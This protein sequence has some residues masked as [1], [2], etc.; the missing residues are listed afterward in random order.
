MTSLVSGYFYLSI[1]SLQRFYR[2]CCGFDFYTLLFVKYKLQSIL[3]SVLWILCMINDVDL[4]Y[5]ELLFVKYCLQCICILL[6]ML[7]CGFYVVDLIYSI[8]LFVKYCLQSE[9]VE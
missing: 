9:I 1:I 8:L 4:I 3:Q 7:S 2:V 5:R 6:S